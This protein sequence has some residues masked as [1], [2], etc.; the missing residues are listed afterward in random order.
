MPRIE[1]EW[2]KVLVRDGTELENTPM[3]CRVCHQRATEEPTLLMRELETPW[4]HFF[5]PQ[6]EV[7]NPGVS[8]SDLLGDYIQAKGGELYAGYA[9]H[10][11]SDMTPFFLELKRDRR[12]RCS[13]TR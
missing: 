7:A 4:T 10:T 3:D 12:N 5:Y 1:S 13:S 6:G 2:R 9:L 8:G 11:I